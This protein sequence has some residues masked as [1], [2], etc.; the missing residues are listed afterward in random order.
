MTIQKD[1]ANV[2]DRYLV[3]GDVFKLVNTVFAFCFK[4]AR[5]LTT[6]GSDIENNENCGQISTNVRLLK[7]EP[8]DLLPHFDK[9]HESEA[10]MQNISVKHLLIDNHD[11]AAKKVN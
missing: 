8:G 3:D 1:V 5:V 4:E 10:R 11:V 7:S 9:I 6:G 2:A